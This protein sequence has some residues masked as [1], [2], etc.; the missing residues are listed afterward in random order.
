MASYVIEGYVVSPPGRRAGGHLFFTV[1]SGKRTVDAIAFEPSKGFRDRLETLRV[2]DFVRIFGSL[3]RGAIKIEKLEVLA[4]ALVYERRVPKCKICGE[5][6]LNVG[7]LKY[8]CTECGFLQDPDYVR[9]VTE[10]G[11]IRMEPPVYARRHL[12]MPWKLEKVNFPGEDHE[13]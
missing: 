12:S 13:F 1:K 6:T 10:S 11:C 8:K 7:S 2:N 3:S 5:K 4:R 9:I